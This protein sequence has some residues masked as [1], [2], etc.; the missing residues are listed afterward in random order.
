MK[1][2]SLFFV[3]ML[4]LRA[5]AQIPLEVNFDS[6]YAAQ[7]SLLTVEDE[8]RLMNVQGLKLSQAERDIELPERVNNAETQYM[9]P[10]FYQYGNE[11]GQAST[12]CYTLSYELLR[13]RN[14]HYMWGFQFSYP[15]RFAW[16]FLNKGSNVGVN[17][18]ESWELIRKAG[19][20]TVSEWGGWYNFGEMTRWI[21]GYEVYHSAMRNRISEMYA[22]HIDNE[23]G[24]LTLKHW[25]YDHLCGEIPGGLANFYCT[26]L[27]NNYLSHIPAGQY[28]A[29]KCILTNFTSNVN[30]AKTIVGYD[31]NVCWDYN[32]DGLYTNDV[33]INGDGVVDM[34][35]WERG[36]VIFCNTF[37]TA[38]ADEGYCYL[39]YCKLASLPAEGGI[40]NSTVY[41]AQVRDEVFPQ[42]TYKV[43]LRH[44]SRNKI[45]VLAG[46]STNV[47][48]TEP[49]FTTDFSIFNYQ[50]GDFYMQGDTTEEAKTIEF[51]LD[52]S[53]LLN[54]IQP[55]LPAKFFLLV[56]ENDPDGVGEGTIVDFSLMDYTSGNAVEQ[57]YPSHNVTIANN[58]STTLSMVRSIA[59]SKPSIQDSVLPTIDAF[60][61]YTH[62]L[63]ATGGKPAYRWQLSRKYEMEHLDANYP[64]E[65][66][67]IVALSNNSNGYAVVPL[68]FDF[69]CYQD[70]YNQIVV[71]ADGYITFHHRS[72]NWPFL[73]NSTLQ[74]NTVRMICPFKADLQNCTVKKKSESGCITIFF[75]GKIQG[76]SASQLQFAVKLYDNGV[77]EFYYGN[78]TYNGSNVWSGLN[79]GD[80]YTAQETDFSHATCDVLAHHKVRLTPSVL[81]EGL[82]LSENGKILGIVRQSFADKT[83]R[84]DCFDNND[85]VDSKM[86][87]V[88]CDY[89]SQLLLSSIK[90]NGKDYPDLL[91]GDTMCFTVS[92]K[93]VDSL[94]YAN[95]NLRLT[96]TDPYVEILDGNEYFGIINPNGEYTLNQCFTCVLSPNIPNGRTVSL[97]IDI[98]NNIAPTSHTYT[99]DVYSQV[100]YPVSYL[101]KDYGSLVNGLFDPVELDSILFT[102]HNAYNQPIENVSLKLHIDHPAIEVPID[103]VHYDMVAANSDFLFPTLLYV[104][105]TYVSGTC[106]NASIDIY[107]HGHYVR[108]VNIP[109]LGRADCL[110]M[111]D[112]MVPA[113]M[114]SVVGQNEWTI[115]ETTAHSGEYC[116]RSGTIA[117]L[118]TTSISLQV[119]A[120]TMNVVQFYLKTSSESNYDCLI[121]CVDD[122]EQ[123]KWSGD[124]DWTLAEFSLEEGRHTLCWKYV[125]D[126]NVS[127]GSDCVWIDDI[128]IPQLFNANCSLAVFPEEVTVSVGEN[129][130]QG[131]SQQVVCE[132]HSDC[133]LTFK[134]CLLNQDGDPVSFV[135]V[136]PITGFIEPG[137][138]IALTL[139]FYTYDCEVGSHAAELHL[140]YGL[141]TL[142]VPIVM[143]VFNNVGVNE[144]IQD[145]NVRIYPNPTT[146]TV[147]INSQDGVITEI[148]LYD[149]FGR[150][151]QT[152]KVA[153]SAA[154]V[155][156]SDYPKGV[157]LLRVASNQGQSTHKII[158]K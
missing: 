138:S 66:G 133:L 119:V 105:P 62:Q 139:S 58:A 84:V 65:S 5:V 3:M 40:W 9:I 10:I 28:E 92:V 8:M 78:M 85:V 69:P 144:A 74:T 2:L 55:G 81:P 96:T 73:Q 32:G 1:R 152:N 89:T 27:G 141:D 68:D 99:Y 102:M 151:L 87:T 43:K 137:D 143:N 82:T 63:T 50:G 22:I 128:C 47:N 150:L 98:E 126:K 51:G 101:I 155:D 127:S 146:G 86:L 49:D 131:F 38:F 120:A 21:S 64:T 115:D 91:E 60:I 29:G 57:T 34:R 75:S 135:F 11:C 156:L 59:F 114:Q 124:Q 142:F 48:A 71:Y 134:N 147:S 158:K 31:D 6:L 93:N 23:E 13:R 15:S 129:G 123:G 153:N 117:D 33:D 53:P 30:H 132:N 107:E 94:T 116:L 45:Q 4:C 109:I 154:V 37:G 112:G 35:D 157:Y 103:S 149:V 61:P 46:V 12:I 72:A 130:Y 70:K 14:Q 80:G 83:F 113:M 39:P 148:V 97:Q 20:P 110:D 19:T 90:V 76:Q 118:D 95:G 25:L 125:K 122:M 100:I 18:M 108:S 26:Y 106:V 104:T 79:Y 42:L 24:L 121:F 88:S 145:D 67:E 56:N 41:V 44:T 17:F 77:I 7:P 140:M 111:E 54:Y 136:D 36:A 52:V 16:N